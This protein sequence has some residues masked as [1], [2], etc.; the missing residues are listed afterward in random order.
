MSVR[1]SPTKKQ[2]NVVKNTVCFTIIMQIILLWSLDISSEKNQFVFEWF[3]SFFLIRSELISVWAHTIKA[4]FL[5]KKVFKESKQFKHSSCIAKY[6]SFSISKV[7]FSFKFSDAEGR[8]YLFDL[9]FDKGQ[10][11]PYTVDAA[12]FGNVAHFINHSCDPSL[13]VFNVWINCLDPDLPRLALFAVRDIVK[14]NFKTFWK[15]SG[16]LWRIE[17][18][19]S[20]SN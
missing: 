8:T 18:T 14:G 12:H 11:N 4:H 20:M 6:F 5:E 3:G 9:D 19:I 1:S 16:F 2:R 10:D 17:S 7:F 15:I 13:A